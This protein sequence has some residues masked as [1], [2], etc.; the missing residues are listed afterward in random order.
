MIPPSQ[1]SEDELVAPFAI[2]HHLRADIQDFERHY[3]ADT[4]PGLQQ[5]LSAALD[6]I[7][8]KA[9]LPMD[10]IDDYIIS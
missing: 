8:P 5:P 10:P 9:N 4:D 3:H 6:E 7:Q 1:W 2:P